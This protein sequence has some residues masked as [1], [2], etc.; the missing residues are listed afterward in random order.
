M[1]LRVGEVI[2]WKGSCSW[3]GGERVGEVDGDGIV[4]CLEGGIKELGGVG[5]VF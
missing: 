5:S 3:V 4:V 1:V 2:F